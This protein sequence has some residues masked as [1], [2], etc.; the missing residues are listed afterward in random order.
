MNCLKRR[1]HLHRQIAVDHDVIIVEGLVLNGQDHF[2]SEI[3]AA[4]A[5]ALMPK[6]VLVSTADLADP[7]KTAEKKSMP[8]YVRL[9]VQPH[10]HYRVLFM[11]T[12]GLLTAA[13]IPVTLD[14]SL[15]LDQQIAEFSLS[16]NAI[17]AL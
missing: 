11:R 13:E 15:R 9:A 1:L 7:R 8:I 2:A 4:L 17:T 14:P 5:Q 16:C 3:N 12:K 6:V 10:P